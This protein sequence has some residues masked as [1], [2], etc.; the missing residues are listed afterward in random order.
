MYAIQVLQYICIYSL[1]LKL[2]TNIKLPF[3][4]QRQICIHINTVL[5]TCNVTCKK[6]YGPQGGCVDDTCMTSYDFT[7]APIE[8]HV[9]KGTNTLG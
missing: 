4:L 7:M 6:Q 9:E 2:Q 3:K 5:L 8:G 1:L